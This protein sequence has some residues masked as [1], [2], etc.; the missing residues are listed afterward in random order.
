M[1]EVI[2]NI[3]TRRSVRKFSSKE[4]SNDILNEIII[5]GLYAPSAMNT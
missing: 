1:N 4:I 5:A 3:I 2:K